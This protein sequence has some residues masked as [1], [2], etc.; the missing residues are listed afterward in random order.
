[1]NSPGNTGSLA[2]VI[3][4]W[5]NFGLHVLL[6]LVWIASECMKC[7]ANHKGHANSVLAFGIIYIGLFILD[8]ATAIIMIIYGAY[9]VAAGAVTTLANTSYNLSNIDV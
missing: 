4:F 3:V 6:T 7:K 2:E 1:V 8:I 5:V 9:F